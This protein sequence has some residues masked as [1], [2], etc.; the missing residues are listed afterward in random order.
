MIRFLV[1]RGHGYTFKSV[2]RS[3]EAPGISLMTYDRLFRSRWLRR[4][5]HVFTD[6]DRLGFWDL[7]LAAESYLELQ[8]LGLPVWNNP[9]RVKLRY[10][11]LRALHN[12]GLNDFNIYRV[13]E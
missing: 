7:E 4:A 1:T 8:K 9:A 6:L 11:L 3:S 10:A 13:D 12:A 2:R 5:T